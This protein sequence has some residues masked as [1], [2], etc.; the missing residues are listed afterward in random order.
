MYLTMVVI[1]VELLI[2]GAILTSLLFIALLNTG[3]LPKPQEH[4]WPTRFVLRKKPVIRIQKG[5]DLTSA[6]ASGS[7]IQ[8]DAM[9]V[10]FGLLTMALVLVALK[11]QDGFRSLND[12]LKLDVLHGGP[13]FQSHGG[14]FVLA[15]AKQNFLT[16]A[17]PATT[18]PG[19]IPLMA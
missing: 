5:T 1:F 9:I 10:V 13:S 15:G 4:E 14:E 2:I 3:V 19:S 8:T 6:A 16:E 17:R 7:A 12:W 11:D 18:R